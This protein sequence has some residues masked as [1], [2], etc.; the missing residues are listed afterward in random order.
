MN[1][2]SDCRASQGADN[3]RR[4][5]LPKRDRLLRRSEFLRVFRFGGRH[6]STELA[7]YAATNPLNRN[8]LGVSVSRKHGKAVKRNRIR[9]LL[10]EAFRLE[11]HNLPQGFDYIC[12][13]A[14]GPFEIPLSALRELLVALARAAADKARSNRRR[15]SRGGPRRKGPA[16]ARVSKQGAS[17]KPAT[18]K[19]KKKQP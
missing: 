18:K 14:L 3:Q 11:N 2:Q 6:S 10:K 15:R 1:A 16:K 5:R 4:Y 19:N 13:P 12:V 17:P 9:R 8:R 7:L